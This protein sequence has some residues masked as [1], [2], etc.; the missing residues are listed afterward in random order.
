MLGPTALVVALGPRPPT[1]HARVL[2]RAV[3]PV[4]VAVS[5]LAHAPGALTPA[6]RCWSRRPVDVDRRP[7]RVVDWSDPQAVAGW[8]AL[9]RHGPSAGGCDRPRA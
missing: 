1:R 7:E 3:A 9:L 6:E 8:R 5:V 4:L 2:T